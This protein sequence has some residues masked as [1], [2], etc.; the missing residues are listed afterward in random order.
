LY[1]NRPDNVVVAEVLGP[2]HA[3]NS[4][5]VRLL[6]DYDTNRKSGNSSHAAGAVVTALLSRL[7]WDA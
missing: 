6:E 5:R 7:W 4:L 3:E 2:G 1:G